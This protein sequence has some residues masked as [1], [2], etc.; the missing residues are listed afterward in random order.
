SLPLP[1][2]VIQ[3]GIHFFEG[4]TTANYNS[5][6]VMPD[7]KVSTRRS[8][9]KMNTRFKRH[10][11]SRLGDQ[12][13]MAIFNRLADAIGFG[14]SLAIFLMISLTEN[15]ITVY[16]YSAHHW[17]GRNISRSKFCQLKATMHVFFV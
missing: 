14:V 17:I 13:G 9:S 12:I 2:V 3:A 10:I 6:N 16:Q 5:W 7:D 4:I 11:Q 1:D 15:S 8:F